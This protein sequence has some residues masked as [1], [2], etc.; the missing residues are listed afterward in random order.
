MSI[1]HGPLNV[2]GMCGDDHTPKK[3]PAM[4][5][6]RL[7]ITP[8]NYI[9]NDL[10]PNDHLGF[11][12]AG[13]IV[14]Y[15]ERGQIYF[16]LI[17]EFRKGKMGWNTIGGKRESTV[18]RVETFRET[19]IREFIEECTERNI[20]EATLNLILSRISDR[21]MWDYRAKM[22]LLLVKVLPMPARTGFRFWRLKD[23][24]LVLHRFAHTILKTLSPRIRAEQ[25]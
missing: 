7:N 13:I 10:Q 1:E 21:V 20:D 18:G 14:Y 5:K 2:C 11:S 6:L 15:I 19:A 3:C 23:P 4:R 17:E 9:S 22:A 24:D 12:A 8:H 25:W 16:M